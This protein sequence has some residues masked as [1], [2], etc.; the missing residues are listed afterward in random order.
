MES[1]TPSS[2]L[3]V[4]LKKDV[5]TRPSVLCNTESYHAKC[6][7]KP[8]FFR[9]KNSALLALRLVVVQMHRTEGGERYG[10]VFY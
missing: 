9:Q 2:N 7:F 1:T 4:W 3:A 8:L 10:S 5:N 6:V